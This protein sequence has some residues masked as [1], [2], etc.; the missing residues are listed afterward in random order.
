[1]HWEEFY[2]GQGAAI[3][4]FS[5]EGG[6][7][8]SEEPAASAAAEV[9]KEPP[10]RLTPWLWLILKAAAA[11]LLPF[12]IAMLAVWSEARLRKDGSWALPGRPQ[13]D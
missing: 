5:V 12:V 2:A 1:M 7:G 3:K 13:E 8:K 11:L 10:P 9:E 4:A 6:G